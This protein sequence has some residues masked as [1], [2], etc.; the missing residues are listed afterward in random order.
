MFKKLLLIVFILALNYGFSFSQSLIATYPFPYAS[1]YNGFWGV[2]QINDTLRIGSSSG[3]KIFK[4]TKTGSITDSLATLFT[5]NQGLAWDGT[6]FW[7]ARN[8]GG[9][10]PRM[11]KVNTSGNPVDSIRIT[12]INGS[13]TIGIGGIALDGNFLWAAVYYPDYA[14]YPFSYAYKF[15]LTTK[16]IVDSIP[17]RGKQVQGIAVKGDTILYVT[18]NFQS[19]Q[20]RIY[21]YRKVVGDTLFSFAAPDPD[22]DCDPR[23]LF[24]DGSHL[25]LIAN[26]VG[27]STA[28]FR[29]LYKYTLTGAGSPIITTTPTSIGFGN[30][31]IGQTGNQNLAINNLGTGKLIISAF[32]FTNPRFSINP[33]A[34]PDTI[35]PGSSKNYSVG[36]TPT[37]FDTTSGELRI[38]NNDIGNPVKVVTLKGKGVQNG[39]YMGLS[40][41]SFN[42]NNRRTNSLCGFTFQVMNQGT[43]PLTINSCNFASSRFRFDTTNARFPITIDTQRTR[44]FRIWFNPNA[45]GNFSDSAVFGSNAVN[46]GKIT[47]TGTGVDEVPVLGN[48]MW[49]SNI[50]DNPNT[51]SDD[52]QPKS[53]KQ[54]PD[55][56]GDGIADMICATENYWTICYNG[57]SSVTADTLWKFNTH[58]GTNNTGSV[59]WEDAMQIMDDLNGDGLPEVVIGCGGG[60]EE[61]YVLSGGT[62]K[63]IWEYDGP[64]S[65]YDGDIFGLRVDK[66]FNGDGRKDVLISASGEGATNPGRHSVICL[67]AVNG[68]VLFNQAQPSEFTYDVTSLTTGGAIG[69]GSNSGVRGVRGFN[70]TGVNVWSYSTTS[71]VWSLREVADLNNDGNSD[72]V[73][74]WGFASGVFALNG[75]TG[76]EIWSTGLGSG[77]NGTVE[78]L[79]DKDNNGFKE[80]T[81][82]GATVAVRLDPKTTIQQWQTP[83]SGSYI[84]DAGILGDIN[85]DSIAEVL[86]STQDPAKVFVLNGSTGVI[87]FEYVFGTLTHRADRVAALNSIDG[88]TA[89]EFVCCSRDGRIKCFSGGP[90]Q[91]IGISSNNGIIPKSFALYQNYP[92]PFNPA[93]QIKF[94]V[95]RQVNVKISVFDVIGREVAVLVNGEMKPGVYDVDW[96]AGNFASGVYFYKIHAGDFSDVKKMILVK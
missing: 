38:S 5:Y 27:T 77:N 48:I 31:I 25:W 79:D 83:L 44:T 70:M 90:G 42:Y 46:S 29:T 1:S 74:F 6:G 33:S 10:N 58:F 8:S 61:V 19:D 57:N 84:R 59:D 92:N 63:L 15:D 53:L 9:S 96:N 17:L 45:S 52:F 82:S 40:A 71:A 75:A 20:E 93:T 50:P 3:G 7:I 89:N 28:Q 4:V 32:N 35:Q 30:V 39:S 62:G 80:L 34:V 21:A 26:R 66:D 72:L 64:G 2:T 73:G 11:V 14:S 76:Q 78:I 12:S 23:G 65:N 49:E 37:V 88:N 41:T 24:W 91:P 60:N 56:N 81:F 94:D 55:V 68:Q 67:N 47:L 22:N 36:F 87:M 54:I 95:A 69:F 86:Y 51:S 18:D 13:S 43:Q 16:A 85:G